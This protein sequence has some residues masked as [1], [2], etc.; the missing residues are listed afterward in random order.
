MNV[1]ALEELA[2][3]LSIEKDLEEKEGRVFLDLGKLGYNKLLGMGKVTRPF[4]I[5]IASYSESAFKKVEEA[6]GKM[7]VEEPTKD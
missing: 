1:G 6:G 4:S 5:K 2:T 7:I 3:K